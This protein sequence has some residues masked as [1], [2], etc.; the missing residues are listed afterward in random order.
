MSFI[1][2][3]NSYLNDQYQF[4][5]IEDKK[6]ALAQVM[7]NVTPGSILGFILFNLYV[8]D[9]SIFTLSTCLQFIDDT[10]LYKRCKVKDIPD[11][12]NIIKKDVEH[13]KAWSDVNSLVFN[14]PKTKTMIFSTRQMSR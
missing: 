1:R 14:G 12:P 13:L 7:C 10:T 11:C 5:Q 4:V 6:P 9:M 8:T 3:I 2:L